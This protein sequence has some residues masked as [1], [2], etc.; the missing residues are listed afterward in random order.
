MSVFNAP[1]RKIIDGLMLF[2]VVSLVALFVT[3][4]V[5]EITLWLSKTPYPK[6][7]P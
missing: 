3:T 6:S 4:H 2:I 7:F 5:P 1:M